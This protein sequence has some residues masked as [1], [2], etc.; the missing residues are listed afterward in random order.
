M[1]LIMADQSRNM[2]K[3]YNVKL[4]AVYVTQHVYVLDYDKYASFSHIL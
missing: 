3:T 1:S 4:Q 2:Y